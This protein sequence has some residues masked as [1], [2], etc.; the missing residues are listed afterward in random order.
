MLTHGDMLR[1]VASAF[2]GRVALSGPQQDDIT[3]RQLDFET[4]RVAGSLRAAGFGPGN[5]AI[6]LD[7]NS[8]RYLVTYFSTAKAGLAFSPVNYW[9]RIGELRH[10][11]ELV[12]PNV[13]FAGHEF[14]QR[15]DEVLGDSIDVLRVATDT[16][17]MANWIAWDD[18]LVEST[19]PIRD[20]DESM[21]HE[22]I[23]TSGTTGN[24]KGVVRSQ[25]KRILDS[26]LGALATGFGGDHHLLW[27]LPQFHIG[28]AAISNQFLIQ[29]GRVTV[30]PHFEPELFA[31]A[32]KTG[33]THLYG[34]P[35]NYRLLLS[36]GALDNVD[37]REVRA[38]GIGGSVSDRSLFEEM[39]LR[40][41][42]AEIVHTYG[43]TESGPHSLVI[44]GQAFL[45]RFGSVG[46]P[47]TGTE[48]RLVDPHSGADV[49]PGAVG[50]LFL[51]GEAVMDEYLGRPDLTSAAFDKGG[52]FRTGDLLREDRDGY[53]S[54]V[55]RVKDMI[56]TGGENVYPSEV[57]DVI[58]THEAVEEVAVVGARDDIYEERV[59][60]F[61]Q[62]VD[63]EVVRVS[64]EELMQWTRERIAGFK[65]PRELH[66]VEAFPR[67]PIGKIAKD[68]L[69]TRI[70]SVFASDTEHK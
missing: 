1:R 52:W 17:A 33:V 25:R 34:V 58:R 6:W 69:R 47:V 24:A 22:I 11:V 65:S 14:Q 68:E 40:F 21:P 18:F 39:L 7:Y 50:E 56:I 5:R 9:L 16:P 43:L 19:A 32:I 3:F 57:E 10:Q 48:V 28:G 55:D 46:T 15:I 13:V 31:A 62:L 44:R 59:V 61:V 20:V 41:P 27:A 51:R 67:T 60:A 2:G 35:A 37:T 49:A 23:F 70:G 4:T 45:D 66:F 64:P 8:I 12:A 63:N 26:L 29:G 36:S 54:V 30:L 38:C 53:Y 42:N